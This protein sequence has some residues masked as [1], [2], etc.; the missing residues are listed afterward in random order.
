MRKRPPLVIGFDNHMYKGSGIFVGRS[1]ESRA[2]DVVQRGR[3]VLRGFGGQDDFSVGFDGAYSGKKKLGL[4]EVVTVL[5]TLF[6][7]PDAV[8]LVTSGPCSLRINRDGRVFVN[9]LP[10]GRSR[11]LFARALAHLTLCAMPTCQHWIPRIIS[12]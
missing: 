9:D 1:P 10:A 3:I 4:N 12:R 2:V 8:E 6:E 11:D 7:S 5:K